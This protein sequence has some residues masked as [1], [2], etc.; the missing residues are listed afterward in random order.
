MDSVC[1]RVSTGAGDGG[2]F[3]IDLENMPSIKEFTE[4]TK[5]RIA[6][7]IL[8]NMKTSG[9][10]KFAIYTEDSRI[11]DVPDKTIEIV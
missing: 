3:F 8:K 1:Y 6:L 4:E 9:F 5:G 7:R 2:D 11:E 10:L